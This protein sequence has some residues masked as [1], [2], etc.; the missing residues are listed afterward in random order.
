MKTL[1]NIKYLR[2]LSVLRVL[3]NFKNSAIRHHTGRFWLWKKILI[4]M[5]ITYLCRLA[6]KALI[7]IYGI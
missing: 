7:N 2:R 6:F 4:M 5:Q 1:Q 3:K